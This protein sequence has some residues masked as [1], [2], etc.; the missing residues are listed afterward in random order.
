MRDWDKTID[1]LRKNIE[2]ARKR[3]VLPY[4][5]PTQFDA[6]NYENKSKVNVEEK[7]YSTDVSDIEKPNAEDP[8]V[9]SSKKIM[10]RSLKKLKKSRR[11]FKK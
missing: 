4:L 2:D 8:Q 5:D 11:K 10:K 1:E 6:K 9:V 3:W 7:N